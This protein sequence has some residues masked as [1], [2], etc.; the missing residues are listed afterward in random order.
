MSPPS[1]VILVPYG[2]DTWP[3]GA[4]SVRHL[5]DG[6]VQLDA[7]FPCAVINK[8]ASKP[9]R[10]NS[11]ALDPAANVSAPQSVTPLNLVKDR[12]K[13]FCRPWDRLSLQFVDG[14]FEHIAKMLGVH[15]DAIAKKL[16]PFVGLYKAEDWAFSAPKPLPR[17][18]LAAPRDTGNVGWDID[19]FVQAD[20]AFWLGDRAVAVLS[21]PEALTPARAKH[22]LARLEQAGVSVVHFNAEN[23]T[24][25]PAALFHRIIG[26]FG[27]LLESAGAVPSSPFRPPEL[28]DH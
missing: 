4:I 8:A 23:L 17:A 5:E 15:Q 10:L 2:V 7:P 14:Y 3:V 24:K 16:A 1:D 27:A 28:G 18:H 21:Q 6:S 19:D 22:R 13:G 12:L 20:F 9:L 11:E 25:D 26:D